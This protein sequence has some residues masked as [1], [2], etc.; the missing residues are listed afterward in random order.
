[1]TV[2]HPWHRDPLELDRFVDGEG[3]AEER[4]SREGDVRRDPALAAAVASRRSFLAAIRRARA[5]EAATDAA[6]RGALEAR[7][8]DALAARP[9]L[10]VVRRPAVLVGGLAVAAALLAGIGIGFL[11][12]GDRRAEADALVLLAANQV[13]LER[14]GRG[15]PETPLRSCSQEGPTS[16][17][18]FPL[19]KRRE[20]DVKGCS[21]PDAPGDAT[22]AVLHR[23]EELPAIGYVA[24][25]EPGAGRGPEIGMTE[26]QDV[27]VFDLAY[28]D[29]RYYLAVDTRIAK[30][31]HPGDRWTCGACHGVS[32]DEDANPHHIVLRRAP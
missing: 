11:G 22:V 3:S 12:G 16:P 15:A 23:P 27:V 30:A 14:A 25:P 6:A 8:R 2:P 19:V 29:T 31:S 24:V 32:R 7:V 4:A 9:R 26:L 28:G 17:Y 20:M 10:R 1:M 5:E 21:S 13:R 18:A